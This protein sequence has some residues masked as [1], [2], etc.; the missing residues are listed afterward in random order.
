VPAAAGP[1]PG[2]D[3]AA[4]VARTTTGARDCLG[5]LHYDAGVGGWLL[6]IEEMRGNLAEL[7]TPPVCVPDAVAPPTVVFPIAVPPRT[8]HA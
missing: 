2:N 8:V 5:F 1:S 4:S 3:S 7:T 6:A